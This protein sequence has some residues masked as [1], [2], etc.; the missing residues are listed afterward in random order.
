MLNRSDSICRTVDFDL[1]L[2]FDSDRDNRIEPV[3]PAEWLSTSSDFDAELKARSA[4]DMSAPPPVAPT[5]PG[6]AF[7]IDFDAE[8]E[9]DRPDFVAPTA[10]QAEELPTEYEPI[11]VHGLEPEFDL[12][13]DHR[14][15]EQPATEEGIEPERVEPV[16]TPALVAESAAEP[17][18]AEA[19]DT[20][21]VGAPG[22]VFLDDEV[23]PPLIEA[24]R[25]SSIKQRVL[26]T[27]ACI[28]LAAVALA[29]G[30]YVFR[31][32]LARAYPGLRAP[33][34]QACANLG[35]DVPYPRDAKLIAVEGTDLIPDSGAA[36]RYR[37]VV[38]LRNRADYPQSWPQLELTLTD[39]F[40]RALSR[41]VIPPR[42]WLPKEQGAR[43]AFE[44]QGE[45]TAN[46]P[47]STD[48][49][50]AGYR[51]YAFYP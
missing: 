36:G 17:E 20:T 47:I 40:D 41:R 48:L 45:V 46:V 39:R 34:E 28:V 5:E 49:P 11:V 33:L 1:N 8:P 51:V 6:Q 26:W 3:P 29:I 50:A 9:E 21:V 4:S 24:P 42:E 23:T 13:I 27:L 35:C 32:D 38:T 43:P 31:T 16:E 7:G 18:Q 15:N 44:A 25:K 37:L 14:E 12:D 19:A 30:A 10:A 22:T 2:D